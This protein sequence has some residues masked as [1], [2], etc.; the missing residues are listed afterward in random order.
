MESHPN[1]N[2]KWNSKLMWQNDQ[3]AKASTFLKFK[4]KNDLN[5]ASMNGALVRRWVVVTC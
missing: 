2:W 3:G 4:L 1:Q 5:Y